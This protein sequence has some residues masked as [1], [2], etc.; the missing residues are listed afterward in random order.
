MRSRTLQ[1][2]PSTAASLVAWLAFFPLMFLLTVRFGGPPVVNDDLDPS[3]TL[4]I[5]YAFERQW[6]WGH[7]IAFTYGPLGFMHPA[8]SY[9]L[10]VGELN[11]WLQIAI[12]ALGAFV[13]ASLFAVVDN[14]RRIAM[15]ATLAVFTVALGA[16]PLW[17]VVLAFAVLAIAYRCRIE[18]GGPALI[19]LVVTASVFASAVVCIKASTLVIVGL[20]Y[21][22]TV[23]MLVANAR[24]GAALAAAVALPISLALV[25][26]AA[27]QKAADLAMYLETGLEFS[28]GYS[29]VM[30]AFPVWWV[31]LAGG[32]IAL[33]AAL[34]VLVSLW[35]NRASPSWIV[36]LGF[37]GLGLFLSWR[38]GYTRADP[39]TMIFF[40]CVG[41]LLPQLPRWSDGILRPIGFVPATIALLTVP[42]FLHE[43]SFDANHTPQQALRA[44]YDQLR[45]AWSELP[46]LRR[47]T[48]SY[49]AS[50]AQATKLLALPKIAAAVGDASVDIMGHH[51]ARMFYNAF[52]YTPRPVFQ[53][54]AAYTSKLALL[55]EAF[56]VGDRA[57]E[58]MLVPFSP[59]DGHLAASEDALSVLALLR[60]YAPVLVEDRFLLLKKKQPPVA[61]IALAAPE[62]TNAAALGE[63]IDLPASSSDDAGTILRFDAELSLPGKLAALLVREPYWFLEAQTAQGAILR[64]RTSR[65]QGKTGFLVTPL[66]N[67]LDDW[68]K[69]FTRQPLPAIVKFRLMP[70]SERLAFLTRPQV[71]YAATKLTAA[72]LPP[73]DAV[74][75][76]VAGYL[77]PGF[78]RKPDRY[79][80]TPERVVEAGKPA[81]FMHAPGTLSFDVAPGTYSLRAEVGIRTA[82][83]TLPA[84]AAADGIV[85]RVTTSAAPTPVFST[86]LDPFADKQSAN[87]VPVGPLALSLPDGGTITLRLEPGEP[88]SNGVCDWS[89]LR[90]LT[91]EPGA[92]AVP[93]TQTG[94]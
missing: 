83:L 92:T 57:P 6:R 47:R 93:A 72:Q 4:A 23:V 32:L 36:A 60:R 7:D 84:C 63:W 24:A 21:V 54:Y 79:E 59:I 9:W 49:A 82:A 28:A 55:N 2:P 12:A 1:K 5:A 3:W 70:H 40:A 86:R 85:I 22:A 81:V 14:T 41:C 20:W 38:L 89:Y 33:A 51:Q 18:G 30:S 62:A 34:V 13:G 66:V 25:W 61:P 10:A 78:T 87:P 71:R 42:M 11:H 76:A 53:S 46:A 74:D 90:D 31:D 29:A 56:L 50:Q 19:A 27:G 16:D 8:A 48:E 37:V 26:L 88:G 80:G 15:I 44:P 91:L 69:L 67:S 58:F 73:A 68:I 64:F 39:H 43:W 65:N 17:I 94:G 77:Y 75:A 35:R 52:N 45:Y